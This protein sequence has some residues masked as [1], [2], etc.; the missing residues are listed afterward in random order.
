MFLFI[1]GERRDAP[2]QF[3]FLLPQPVDVPAAPRL[4]DAVD[5]LLHGRPFALEA[6]PLQ[7][8]RARVRRRRGRGGGRD[9]RHQLGLLL[10]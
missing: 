1:N 5:F 6:Q 4:L 10:A 9:A 8:Q 3:V 7:L 2:E